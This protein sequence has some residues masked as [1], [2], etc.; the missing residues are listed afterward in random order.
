MSQLD[1]LNVD[2]IQCICDCLFQRDVKAL[3]LV[4]K[5]MSA[6]CRLRFRR[7]FLSPNTTNMEAFYNIIRH[8]D[9]RLQVREIVWDDTRFD[10]E[11]LH[12]GNFSEATRAIYANRL[13]GMEKEE[14][15]F[16]ALRS[17]ELWGANHV[18]IK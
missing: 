7:V 9:Y 10:K 5:A 13:V 14:S 4:S 12:E 18:C 16:N 17:K 8:D 11:Y 2:V 6:R 15:H 3:R 1:A